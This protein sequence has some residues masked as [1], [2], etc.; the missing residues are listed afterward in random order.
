MILVML[1]EASLAIVCL[2]I[3]LEPLLAGLVLFDEDGFDELCSCLGFGEGAVP[4]Q[5]GLVGGLEVFFRIL[6]DEFESKPCMSAACAGC[7]S[8]SGASETQPG[9]YSGSSEPSGPGCAKCLLHV[10]GDVF[11]MSAV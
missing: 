6:P 5:I 8:R 9:Q 3:Q 10:R 1:V 11:R 7:T 4:G 2:D